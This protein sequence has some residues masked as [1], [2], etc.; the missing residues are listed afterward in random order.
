MFSPP[1]RPRDPGRPDRAEER[2][3]RGGLSPPKASGTQPAFRRARVRR[4]PRVKTPLTRESQVHPET[5]RRKDMGREGQGNG[6][7]VKELKMGDAGK[8]LYQCSRLQEPPFG[9]RFRYFNSTLC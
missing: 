4:I 9:G 1:R 7:E 8:V 3:V 6:R 5:G 2:A